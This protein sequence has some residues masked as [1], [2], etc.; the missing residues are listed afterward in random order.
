[1]GAVP[2]GDFVNIYHV[3]VEQEDVWFIGRVLERP[4]ITTQGRSLDELV[5]MVR[6]AI[7]LMWDERAVQLELLVPS[8]AVTSYE[9]KKTT[10]SRSARRK[11]KR[12]A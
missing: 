12:A 5:F 3:M 8:R 2:A 7:E 11:P 4:G 1:L 9:R 10:R 6:D